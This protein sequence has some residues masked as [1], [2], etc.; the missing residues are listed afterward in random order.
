MKIDKF[1][2]EI[3]LDEKDFVF[4]FFGEAACRYSLIN[5]YYPHKI[6]INEYE[7]IYKKEMMSHTNEIIENSI[8][9]YIKLYNYISNKHPNTY[10]L[11]AT[12]A[13][14][15]IINKVKYF[16]KVL[17]S[18]VTKYVSIFE[19]TLDHNNNIKYEFLNY[20]FKNETVYLHYK[21]YKYDPIHMSNN[22]SHIF[23]KNVRNLIKDIK[24]FDSNKYDMNNT[25]KCIMI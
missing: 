25:Y 17:K 1:F 21:T 24:K 5:H 20:N 13:F 19:E 16:N 9:N 2:N 22:L 23:I 12:T 7:H 18:K 15:P 8:T 3:F 11:S 10:I 14:F 4:L 6:P